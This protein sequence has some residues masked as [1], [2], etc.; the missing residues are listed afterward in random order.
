MAKYY[1]IG[2][3]GNGALAVESLVHLAAT[4]L[5]GDN[6]LIIKIIDP[7]ETNENVQRA[8]RVIQNYI[9][10]RNSM[11]QD[12][13]QFFKTKIK[14]DGVWNPNKGDNINLEHG[15]S[16]IQMN[17][18]QSIKYKYLTN[19]LFSEEK[20]KEKLDKGY[21]GNPMI[22]TIFM[23]DFEETDIYNE[24]ISEPYLNV[25][26]FGSLFGGTGAAGLPVVGKSLN[27]Y[28][29]SQGKKCYTGASIILPYFNLQQPNQKQSDKF[30]EL[31]I[32]LKPDSD[33]FLPAIKFAIPF[34]VDKA[35]EKENGYDAIYLLGCP[36][37]FENSMR[38]FA[39]GGMDQN[40]KSH[41]VNLYAASSFI[42]FM[43]NKEYNDESKD[44]RFYATK[45]EKSNEHLDY[46]NLPLVF[47]EQ[48]EKRMERFYV[49]AMFYL[50]YFLKTGKDEPSSMTWF[51][52][53][54]K[55]L[56][57]KIDFFND[58][59]SDNLKEYFIKFLTWFGQISNNTLSLKTFSTVF[60]NA[61]G[62]RIDIE[63]FTDDKIGEY[64]VWNE[65]PKYGFFN[66]RP[67]INQLN[68]HFDSSAEGIKSKGT[69]GNHALLDIFYEGS[70]TFIKK[71]YKN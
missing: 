27:D 8:Q 31:E 29:K 49:S 30:R 19:L 21:K 64:L 24:M 60:Y 10:I 34:Y 23:K 5:V 56:G 26:V 38:E 15:I 47:N 41:Y 4:G 50:K 61:E 6:E 9:S 43:N 45:V 11:S 3:G 35:E 44:T 67:E 59:F 48:A 25:F 32:N 2:I 55:G 65:N 39:I 18:D 57:L 33:N 16:Y 28:I 36:D 71:Y 7:D 40:N 52:N 68:V 51:S 17:N 53:D 66:K 37:S 54:K 62:D 20:R 63:S 42:D 69:G 12:V 13:P 46:K 1:I 58:A 70:F 22:G 14:Y